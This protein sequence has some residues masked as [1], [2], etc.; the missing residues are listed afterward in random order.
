MKRSNHLIQ[1]TQRVLLF[2]GREIARE[3]TIAERT[4]EPVALFIH[5]EVPHFPAN[6]TRVHLSLSR[7]R[8][9]GGG[10]AIITQCGTGNR[11]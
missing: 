11:P 7:D 4:H 5:F 3:H 1:A 8:V 2:I 10:K 6:A 9:G